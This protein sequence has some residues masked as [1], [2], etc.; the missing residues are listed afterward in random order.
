MI[1]LRYFARLRE[2]VGLDAEA[3]EPTA[4]ATIAELR[5]FLRARGEP[6]AHALAPE[7]RILVA[8]NQEMARPETLVADGD[9]VAF[10]PPVTG[11]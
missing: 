1:E 5:A 2:Q 6:W 10:F 4:G 3:I 11:G 9:E 8:L 7:Q